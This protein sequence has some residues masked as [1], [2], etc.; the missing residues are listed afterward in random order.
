VSN[1]SDT[2][3]GPDTKKLDVENTKEAAAAPVST[4][5]AC[6]DVPSNGTPT[7]V[8]TTRAQRA[9]IQTLPTVRL[10]PSN[11]KPTWPIVIASLEQL[12]D[13]A[14]LAFRLGTLA[15]I[16]GCVRELAQDNASADLVARLRTLTDALA[17][18]PL[19]A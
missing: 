18:M 12:S 11:L 14:V 8:A 2:D 3:T 5:G 13:W 19:E 16:Q 10:D 1:A 7:P 15:L 6:A 4:E 17:H 9:Q